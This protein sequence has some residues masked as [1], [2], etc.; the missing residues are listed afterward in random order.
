VVK[1]DFLLWLVWL[2]L[3]EK[4]FLLFCYSFSSFFLDKK[5]SKKIKA[6]T[7][8]SGRF[9]RQRFTNTLLLTLTPKRIVTQ[10]KRLAENA[11][12]L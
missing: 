12:E 8:A 1:L 3:T 6:N 2:L 5:R 11:I 9:A 4:L 7:N 10:K